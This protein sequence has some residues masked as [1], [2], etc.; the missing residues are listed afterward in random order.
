MA[1]ILKSPS[2]LLIGYDKPSE[3]SR[4]KIR[5]WRY[6]FYGDENDDDDYYDY[7]ATP[8]TF[9]WAN[10][11]S[12]LASQLILAVI[13]FCPSL[14]GAYFEVIVKLHCE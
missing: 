11:F 12:V 10:C 6:I 14:I 8:V 1:M 13:L 9:T 2:W 4:L 7:C 3:P 5:L